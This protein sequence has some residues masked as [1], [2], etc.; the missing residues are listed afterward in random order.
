MKTNRLLLALSAVVASVAV[1]GLPA[2]QA[3]TPQ[4]PISRSDPEWWASAGRFS[5]ARRSRVSSPHPRRHRKRYWHAAQPDPRSARR[6]AAG[7]NGR[8]CRHERQ[9]G[10]HRRQTDWRRV[11]RIGQLP[12]G[13]DR[14]HYPHRG[15]DGCDLYDFHTS[16]R[17]TREGRFPCRV[18]GTLRHSCS[19]HPESSVCRSPDDA[20]IQRTTGPTGV[21]GARSRRCGR[22]PHHRD[23]DSDLTPPAR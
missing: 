21:G 19:A 17:H 22:L 2:L 13:T 23:P 20:Q 10:L 8:H 16:A 11:V 18:M 7:A 15:D 12:Q 1:L 5:A 6:R 9:P 4:M 3:D 14:R